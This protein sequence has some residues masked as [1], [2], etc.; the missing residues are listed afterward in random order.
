MDKIDV[1]FYI[2]LV[3]RTDRRA[4]IEEQCKKV[5]L[6]SEKVVRI[7]AIKRTPGTLGCIMSHIKTLETFLA[8][9]EQKTALILE[10]DFIFNA[11]SSAEL[12]QSLNVL[13]TNFPFWDVVNLAVHA[14]RLAYLDTIVP[15]IKKALFVLTTSG[16]LVTRPM[17]KKLLDNWR[18][19]KQLNEEL[20]SHGHTSLDV[21]WIS[22]QPQSNWYFFWPAIG[23]QSDGYSDILN[24]NTSFGW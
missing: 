7:D 15:E 11:K 20:G 23:H 24:T 2:N 1:I 4:S 17:A 10:D 18:I 5:G 6:P 22:M 21:S 12:D 14:E 13:F 16:Y 3:H 8:N 19:V 9:P